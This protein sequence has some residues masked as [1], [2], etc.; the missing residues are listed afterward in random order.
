MHGNLS[1]FSMDPW[2]R[3]TSAKNFLHFTL[4]KDQGMWSD[5]RKSEIS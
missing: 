3:K 4:L 5:S 1:G 2:R